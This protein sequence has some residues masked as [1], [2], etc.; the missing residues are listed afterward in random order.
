MIGE[1]DMYVREIGS[2]FHINPNI[3]N[4]DTTIN[5]IFFYLRSFDK[6]LFDSG[7]SALL[8][9]LM[10]LNTHKVLL[11]N[12]ICESVRES[13]INSNVVYYNID[14]EFKIDWEDLLKKCNDNNFDILYLYFFNG[15]IDVNYD[16]DKLKKIKREKKF[17]IIEDT[18]HSIF[19]NKRII[20]D[21][22]ICS[23]RKWFPIADGGILY[24][25]NNL[26]KKIFELNSWAQKKEKAMI[27]KAAYLRCKQID[28]KSF[29]NIL[30]ES[31]KCLDEQD[32]PFNISNGSYDILKKININDIICRRKNNL[33]ILRN[34]LKSYNIK[35]F[36]VDGINQVP[37]FCPIKSRMRDEL[38]DY[39]IIN[40]I[41]CPTH[42]P[43]YDE[44]KI[45]E[46]A[47]NN[48]IEELT[49]PIDQRYSEEDMRYIADKII[50]FYV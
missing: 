23:L 28:K 17:I 26:N 47:L 20:G 38:K 1:L 41:Y 21:Y 42:W 25:K 35:V 36:A 27:D 46:V 4:K 14:S 24:S 6:Q 7:R 37:I 11:P 5:N 30:R 43:L 48:S 31:E 18:T 13:F 9:L 3:F 32:M 8:A 29:F 22:C 12:Y 16:F 39:L 34:L 19:S 15:Y 45:Y 10:D 50:N 40:H 44:L 49:I 33:N 2:D